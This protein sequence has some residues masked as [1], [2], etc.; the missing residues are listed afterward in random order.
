MLCQCKQWLI[1]IIG[2]VSHHE[3]QK[4]IRENNAK[5]AGLEAHGR[6]LESIYFYA[7]RG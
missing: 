4:L 2:G 5:L 7:G 1:K 6:F 3:H